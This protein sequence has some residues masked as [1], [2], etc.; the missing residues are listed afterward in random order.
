MPVA[1]RSKPMTRHL[2]RLAAVAGTI[3]LAACTQPAPQIL[4][5]LEYERI[6]LPSPAAER[7]VAI[8]VH[9][10]ERVAE[11][12][13]LLQL[14]VS[15]TQAL[16]DADQ[17]QIAAQEQVLRELQAGPRSEAIARAKAQ[18][19]SA[20]A[21]ARNARSELKRVQE[22]ARKAYFSATDL[23]RAR[24]AAT[25]AE[26]Q[27]DVA[28]ASLT[29][30][31]RGT[32][33]EQVAQAEATLAA[34]QARRL[35]EQVV[36]DKLTVR[37]PRA[38]VVDAIPYKLGDQAPVGA[39]LTILLVGD[40]PYARIYVPA[41]QRM[42]I[43]VGDAVTVRVAGKALQGKVRMI[44]SEPV[45]TPYYALVGEDATRLSYLAEV[46]LAPDQA[47]LPAGLP[48]QVELGGTPQ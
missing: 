42:L 37:A 1:R 27:L 48:V 11:A 20:E 15:Y 9:E 45:F 47:D 17:A 44:R 32:R 5:T 22:L 39:P 34:A 13:V 21:N 10:G 14:D 19:A 43:E 30:L 29:E 8:A 12:Q 38:G 40:A 3:L 25:A 33:P 35:A 18:V 23:D 28:K 24:T 6:T 41:T 46:A 16:L 2:R 26:A 7:I 4:G 36:L 31:Q